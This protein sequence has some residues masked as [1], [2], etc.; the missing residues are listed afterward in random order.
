M[1]SQ[2]MLATERDGVVTIEL[3][4]PTACARSSPPESPPT[5]TRHSSSAGGTPWYEAFGM[6]ESGAALIVLPRDHDEVV[7]RACL[8]SPHRGREVLVADPQ[9]RP[10]PDGTPGELLVRGVGMM[11][12]YWG[13][14]E[15][16]AAAFRDGWLRSGDEVVMDEAGR[17]F[18]R[19]RI[20]DMVRRSGEN[21][22]A[23]Q[24]EEA[25]LPAVREHCARQLAAF[26]VPRYWEVRDELPMTPSERVSKAALRQDCGPHVDLGAARADLPA[27]A[28]TRWPMC[29]H[30][31]VDS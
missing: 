17:V 10:V 19:G 25:V 8:G 6:T 28:A 20:K 22:S 23:A 4:R 3:N 2:P 5:C 14:P 9:G 18:F 26:K 13:R 27:R 16:T 15:A 21:V 1:A 31:A 24:V 7:G 29:R 30:P 12:G 11:D